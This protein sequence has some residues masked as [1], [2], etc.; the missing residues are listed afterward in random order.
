MNTNNANS[1]PYFRFLRFREDFDRSIKV[2]YGALQ[3]VQDNA[4]ILD[5]TK[6]SVGC[7]PWGKETIWTDIPKHI[8]SS[9]LFISQLGLVRI[10][11]AFEDYL[12][13]IRDEYN[14]FQ[15]LNGTSPKTNLNLQGEELPEKP[16][17]A[18]CRDIGF[19]IEELNHLLPIYDY[20]IETRNCIAHRAGRASKG[21][22][23]IAESPELATCLTEW[24]GKALPTLPPLKFG[25]PIEFMP[26]HAI[27]ASVIFILIAKHINKTLI[28]VIGEKG[29]VYM[30]S[31]HGLLSADRIHTGAL[32]TPESFVNNILFTRYRVRDHKADQ[33]PALL[34]AI[35]K[36]NDC[37]H[38]HKKIIS[39]VSPKIS[40]PKVSSKY[41][42]I[43]KRKSR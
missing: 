37:R 40:K 4:G 33:T 25:K 27:L 28:S 34:K 18:F 24:A 11:S 15:S 42:P 31:Y 14:R 6:L 7:E 3:L 13:G 10:F 12:S 20:I 32:N 1:E 38:A 19:P 43:T 17:L 22:I 23:K 5:A 36:W 30:A 2:T 21:L 41:K 16:L 8:K 9:T 35:G 39:E 26:R 29:L